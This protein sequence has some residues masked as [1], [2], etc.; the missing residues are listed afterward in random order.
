MSYLFSGHYSDDQPFE[1][2]EDGVIYRGDEGRA[3]TI[4][5]TDLTQDAFTFSGAEFF[6]AVSTA[7]QGVDRSGPGTDRADAHQR[8]ARDDG[9]RRDA[10]AHRRQ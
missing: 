2:V 1:L 3:F 9:Q 7:V 5:D 6:A 10:W 4:V 8:S